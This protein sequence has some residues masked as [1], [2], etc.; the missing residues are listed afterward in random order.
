METKRSRFAWFSHFAPLTTTLVAVAM[1]VFTPIWA[2]QVYRLPFIGVL[3][4]PN[5]IVSK[6]TGENWP[7]TGA[8]AR[9]PDQLIAVNGQPVTDTTQFY[10]ALEANGFDSLELT[11]QRPDNDVPAGVYLQPIHMPLWDFVSLFVIPYLVG[12]VFLVIGVWAYRL[13]S[14]LR[15]SH[16]LLVFSASVSVATTTFFDMNTSHHVVALW[17]LSLPVAASACIH[18][19]LVFPQQ[20]RLVDR[21]PALRFI[22]WILC[23]AF[24]VPAVY[25]IL[26]PSG[27]L[28]YISGWQACY[29]FMAL[30]MGLL[31]LT[32]TWRLF[33]SDSPV[34][35][36]QSRVIVFGAALAFAPMMLFYLLPTALGTPQEFR[37]SIYFPL[38]I[39]LPLSIT[40]AI[41]R[42]RLLDVDRVL[43]NVL[44]YAV[45]TGAAVAIFFGL[46]TLLS[47]LINQTV[48]PDNPLLIAIYLL[49]LVVGLSPL[50]SLV[51]RGI[52]RLFYRSPADYRRV[53]NALST[54]L[55][56][57]P[58]LERTLDLLAEQ[59]NQALAPE[60]FII[61]LY[62]DDQ[63]LY[64]PHAAP[65]GEYPSFTP[66][67]LLV[68]AIREA[69]ASLYFPP[70][71]DLPS[72][73]AQSPFY[74]ALNCT[75]FIPLRYE[76]SL[77]GFMALGSKRSG[78]PYNSE[79]LEFLGTV[80]G[81]SALALENARLFTNLRRTLDQTLEMK[82]LMDDIFASIA[83]GVITTDVERKITLFNRASENILGI[84]VKDVVGKHLPDALPLCPDMETA[85]AEAV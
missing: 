63:A 59:L 31:F 54:N 64:L 74:L 49:L 75:A 53:L 73:L 39:I 85:A 7:A 77:I 79:D 84:S 70:D 51:Q 14:G 33:R 47:L 10:A 17:T 58:N 44:A 69:K 55:V 30:A 35:R 76:G 9:W 19:A 65:G 25:E 24:A 72:G 78:D 4:E 27:T 37:A 29:F 71:G 66:D 32:L 41:L 13:R 3:L 48:R 67:D 38:L 43:A 12:L 45:V 60:R 18:L 83:T 57:T 1:L 81:Q 2:F 46:V 8:G 21:W 52:D 34:V 26:Y 6:I 15:A 16:A 23:L 22:S 68:A 11:F 42:Y 56:I 28:N 82:N 5:N 36:Q 62:N 40:Y 50:R 80:A 20:M 61:Y